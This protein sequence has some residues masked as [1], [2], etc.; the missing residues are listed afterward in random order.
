[1]IPRIVGS[2]LLAN[3]VVSYNHFLPNILKQNPHMSVLEHINYIQRANADYSEDMSRI[4]TSPQV[5]TDS[6]TWHLRVS[7]SLLSPSLITCSFS[8]N[9]IGLLSCKSMRT[10]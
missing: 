2:L 6:N 8:S 7:L 10:G 1:M 4:S 9:D 5:D 3:M